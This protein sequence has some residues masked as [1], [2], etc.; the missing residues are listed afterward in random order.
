MYFSSFLRRRSSALHI[1]VALVLAAILVVSLV[2]L[3]NVWAKDEPI[4]IEADQMVSQETKN[5][6]VF[7]GNVDAS[8]GKITIRTDKMTVHYAPKGEKAKGKAGKVKKLICVGSV[9][10]SQEDWLGTGQR[11]DY[12]ADER[13]VV[14][15]GDAK[16]WQGQNMVSGKSITYYLDEKRSVVE[17]AAATEGKKKSGRVKAVIRQ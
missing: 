5:T 13:K 2:G 15:S 4:N 14:L 3:G 7:T 16:A 11:M 10:V 6:V 1:L 17:R 9:E 8:Q 12:Y